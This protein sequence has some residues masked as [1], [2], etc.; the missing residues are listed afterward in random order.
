MI[1]RFISKSS[2]FT[3]IEVLIALVILAVAFT[4]IIAAL[5]NS[6][7]GMNQLQEKITAHWVAQNVLAGEQIGLIAAPKSGEKISGSMQMLNKNWYWESGWDEGDNNS[8]YVTRVY[9]QV[10]NDSDTITDTSET[11]T[12]NVLTRLIGFVRVEKDG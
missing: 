3:L 7:R 5:G 6:A 11:E 9:V 2:G 8:S 4:A 1:I 12:S 10:K